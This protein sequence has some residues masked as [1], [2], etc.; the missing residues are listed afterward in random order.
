M[1]GCGFVG[2]PQHCILRGH[3]GPVSCLF[4][5]SMHSKAYSKDHLL[6]GGA[7]FT[8]KLWSLYSGILVHTFAVH[9]GKI[10]T[11]VSC[12]PD[13]NVSR[14]WWEGQPHLLVLHPSCVCVSVATPPNLRV[15]HSRGLFSGHFI[16]HGEE[17][18]SGGIVPLLSC[19]ICPLAPGRRLSPGL[20]YQWSPLRLAD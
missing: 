11:I 13:Y 3:R 8:V 14:G 12:P 2:W 19:E 18:S 5:P 6:S 1:S 10:R 9:G 20:L 17:V 4:Y 15:F 7:D 16:H